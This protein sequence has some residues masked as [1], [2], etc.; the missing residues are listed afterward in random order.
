M[1]QQGALWRIYGEIKI[2]RAR[3]WLEVGL[4]AEDT[5]DL[6][7]RVNLEHAIPSAEFAPVIRND[8]TV[9]NPGHTASTRLR[10]GGGDDAASMAMAAAPG[11][12]TKREELGPLMLDQDKPQPEDKPLPAGSL[13]LEQDKHPPAPHSEL[14]PKFLLLVLL[15]LLLL[16]PTLLFVDVVMIGM[17]E[18]SAATIAAMAAKILLLGL[19]STASCSSRPSGCGKR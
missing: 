11:A 5:A 15:L 10:R 8:E 3:L 1:R 7:L 14:W 12:A 18:P 2:C 19:A 4:P 17:R 6:R 16:M 9:I 13:M